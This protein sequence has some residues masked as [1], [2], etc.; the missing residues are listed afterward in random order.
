MPRFTQQRLDE[1]FPTFIRYLGAFFL[2]MLIIAQVFFGISD[3]PGAYAA[4]GGMILY[5]TFD[6][7]RRALQAEAAQPDDEMDVERWSHLP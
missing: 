3:Y 7:A 4:A 5:K 1:W 2:S 6:R